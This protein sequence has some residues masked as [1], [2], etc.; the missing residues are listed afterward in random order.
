MEAK[1]FDILLVE[2]DSVD[3]MNVQRS[4]ERNNIHNKLHIARDGIEALMV[5]RGDHVD[6]IE[7]LPKVV[8]L[9]INMPR[10]N[11]IEF[12]QEIRKDPKLK[13]LSVFILTTSNYDKD[14]CQ[15]YNLQR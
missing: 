12:L 6:K 7:P 10:M 1:D 4:F 5:L 9:D 8:L 2:D 15:A 11:G 13:S 14:R 3:I